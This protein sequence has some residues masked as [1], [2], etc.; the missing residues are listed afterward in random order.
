MARVGRLCLKKRA[1]GV[2]KGTRRHS[3][4]NRRI[5]EDASKGLKTEALSQKYGLTD[6]RIWQIIKT[7]REN[8]KV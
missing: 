7:I 1:T 5:F 2:A 3:E 8:G 4:R 6:I